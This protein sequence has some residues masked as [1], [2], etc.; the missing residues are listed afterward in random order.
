MDSREG[1]LIITAEKL[2][3]EETVRAVKLSFL[4]CCFVLSGCGISDDSGSRVVGYFIPEKRPYDAQLFNSYRQVE[5]GKSNSTDVL[6]VIHLA[7]YELLSQ[8][9]SVIVST[10]QQKEGYKTW[11]DMAAFDENEMTVKRKYF[12]EID[13]KPRPVLFD[14]KEP[15]E[16]LRFDCDV[17]LPAKL[18]NEPYASENA[19]RIA[20]L[21][22]ILEGFPQG[23]RRCSSGQ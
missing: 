23:H 6:A 4:V 17:V 9:K 7:D 15:L 13:E 21:K 22:Q 20:I 16:G 8:S 19:K 14:S 5:I 18:L 1:S 12:F 10:G 11:F 3:K 2:L